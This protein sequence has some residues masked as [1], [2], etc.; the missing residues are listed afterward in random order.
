MKKGQDSGI[1][2]F[3]G[4]SAAMA[5]QDK[6]LYYSPE[7]PYSETQYY[8][9]KNLIEKC[10]KKSQNTKT[11]ALNKISEICESTKDFTLFIDLLPSWIF[12]FGKMI[13]YDMDKTVR[14]GAFR[15]QALFF[16]KF[17]RNFVN[18]IQEIFTPLWLGRNDPCK[19]VAEMAK[20]AFSTAFPENKHVMVVEKCIEKYIKEVIPI[21]NKELQES[22][23][24]MERL[25]SCAL[26]GIKDALVMSENV[27]QHCRVFLEQPKVWGFVEVAYRPLVRCAG[28]MC[29]D[30]FLGQGMISQDLLNVAVP[31]IFAL[32]GEKNRLIQQVLWDKIIVSIMEKF[33]RFSTC[34]NV[35]KILSELAACASRAASGAGPSFYLAIVKVLSLIEKEKL[36]D[37]KS[38]ESILSGIIKG[39]SSEEGSFHGTYA[40]NAFYE[41]L[42]YLYYKVVNNKAFLETHFIDPVILYLNVNSKINATSYLLSVPKLLTQTLSFLESK[43]QFPDITKPIT[44]ILLKNL[45]DKTEATIYFIEDFSKNTQENHE[46]SKTLVCHILTS[47]YGQM[48]IELE[49]KLGFA[50]Q[51]SIGKITIEDLGDVKNKLPFYSKLSQLLSNYAEPDAKIYDWWVKANNFSYPQEL[52]LLLS[53]VLFVHPELWLRSVIFSLSDINSLIILMPENFENQ[54]VKVTKT[55]DFVGVMKDIL[56]RLE[57]TDSLQILG[58]VSICL[59]RLVRKDMV[60]MD[61]LRESINRIIEN[62]L[63]VLGMKNS[64][65]ENILNLSFA[66]IFEL[67]SILHKKLDNT[68]AVLLGQY[69]AYH[70]YK[71]KLNDLW[72]VCKEIPIETL[73]PIINTCQT[74][75]K[76]QLL[77]SENWS[78]LIPIAKKLVSISHQPQQTIES[79]FTA[80]IFNNFY[81][82]PNV[83]VLFDH[84]VIQT[85]IKI[86]SSLEQNPWFLTKVLGFSLVPCINSNILLYS[87]LQKYVNSTCN[88]LIN[89]KVQAHDL[90]F[91]ENLLKELTQVSKSYKSFRA[92]QI[93]YLKIIL[94]N[95]QDSSTWDQNELLSLFTFCMNNI[96]EDSEYTVLI[97][98]VVSIFKSVLSKDNYNQTLEKWRNLAFETYSEVPIRIYSACIPDDD[99]SSLPQDIQCLEK[100]IDQGLRPTDLSLALSIVRRGGFDQIPQL[101]KIELLVISILLEGNEVHEVL[102]YIQRLLSSPERLFNKDHLFELIINLP[103]HTKNLTPPQLLEISETFTRIFS[104]AD[105]NTDEESLYKILSEITSVNMSKSVYA[106]LEYVYRQVEITRTRF[107]PIP[108]FASKLL[109]Y[110]PNVQSEVMEGKTFSYILTWMLLIEKYRMEKYHRESKKE[111]LSEFMVCFK[112]LLENTPEIVTVFLT[113]L[114]GYLHDESELDS[115]FNVAWTDVL[116]EDSCAKLCCLA[117]F[118]FLSTFPSLGR[119]WWLGCDRFLSNSVQKIVKKLISPTIL[120]QEI[121]NIEN[122]QVEWKEKNLSIETSKAARNI[123]AVF[124]KSEFTVQVSLQIPTDY[125]LSPPEPT[126]TKK[127]KISED[128]VRRWLLSMVQLLQQ[129]N[130]SLLE[131]LLA[132]KEHVERGLDGIEDCY[133]CY[134]LVHPT[135]KSLPNLPCQVCQNKFHK[136]CIQKWFSSSH[137]ATCPLCR[138]P[139]RS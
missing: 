20:K 41:V 36:Q 1:N 117:M 91:I 11:K 77:S 24:L 19:E 12:L 73:L 40:L 27:R 38:I 69:L 53:Q 3:A 57:S 136:L 90:S 80:E 92:I 115:E 87:S 64:V 5:S 96:Q 45:S 111:P 82:C 63:G 70:G 138:N 30:E 121:R 125:P 67:F 16:S 18:Y 7:S 119:N 108:E 49:G 101:E 9:L 102:P 22:E 25:M 34:V 66:K 85:S 74:I 65:S 43:D 135:D 131:L 81:T 139:F 35:A 26:L 54:L 68:S 4:F 75:L 127:V 99:L 61:N 42:L 88:P 47:C 56:N 105:E 2:L 104:I 60:L 29:F 50:N 126:V 32:I 62:L 46:K 55:E 97:C 133:I 8:E 109:S 124:S 33:P 130:S 134:Y 58:K 76:D 13:R 84:L 51:A 120:L 100:L 113:T 89:T 15:V 37:K 116:N 118:K 95:D 107:Q 129:E 98:D 83:W 103:L 6:S 44:E 14:E 110:V 52:L 122:R 39:L 123:T 106:L 31:T 28:L 72:E 48:S 79:F 94:Q 112:D 93:K 71:T 132:W 114:M 23:E 137:N 10:A 17:K 128:K 59:Q 78:S 21:L 86:L